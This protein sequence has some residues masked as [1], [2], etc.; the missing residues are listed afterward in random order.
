MTEAERIAAW[1]SARLRAL[2]VTA[3]ERPEFA[4]PAVR[5][6]GVIHTDYAGLGCGQFAL[7]DSTSGHR[8]E[9][10][11]SACRANLIR[12][13]G[14]AESMFYVTVEEADLP[15]PSPESDPNDT[16]GYGENGSS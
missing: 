4:A 3:P 2:G 10:T 6:S 12:E 7:G 16:T 1:R 5:W 13:G 8:P 14:M 11:C 15:E 9:A